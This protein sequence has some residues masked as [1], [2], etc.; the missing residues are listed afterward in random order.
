LGLLE[1]EKFL[2]LAYSAADLFVLPTLQDNFPNTALESLSCGLPVV[3]FKVGGV[4]E[5]VREGCTG[6][7]A[8]AGNSEALANAIESLLTDPGRRLEMAANCRRI[9]VEEYRLEIQA[10]RYLELYAS[11]L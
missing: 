11:M 3:G 8:E 9:A 4:P 5:I 10:R 1:D 2:S 6:L 7:L